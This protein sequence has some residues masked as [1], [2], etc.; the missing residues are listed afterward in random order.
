MRAERHL[1]IRCRSAL[2]AGL[3]KQL[4]DFLIQVLRNFQRQRVAVRSQITTH[5]V[6]GDMHSVLAFTH[7]D[8]DRS[9][10]GSVR[11]TLSHLFHDERIAS[12]N[13]HHLELLCSRVFAKHCSWIK[14]QKFHQIR[15]ADGPFDKLLILFE[16]LSGGFLLEVSASKRASDTLIQ[17]SKYLF[18]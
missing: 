16:G 3:F 13:S 1:L 5:R 15:W 8:R 4:D 6:I 7:Q 18:E 9:V 17:L 2:A 10:G 11:N 12:N 14:A